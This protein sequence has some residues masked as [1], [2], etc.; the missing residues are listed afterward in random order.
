MREPAPGLEPGASGYRCPKTWSATA[1]VV[2]Q[3][4]ADLRLCRA[5][6]REESTVGR[7]AR[8]MCV[9]RPEQYVTDEAATQPW[10]S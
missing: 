10:E 4:P 7:S 1:A 2:R 6:V 3:S 9:T 8:G 5:N